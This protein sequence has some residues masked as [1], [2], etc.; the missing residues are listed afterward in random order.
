MSNAIY[1]YLLGDRAACTAPPRRSC[2]SRRRMHSPRDVVLGP[3]RQTTPAR[4]RASASRT[5]D[6][7]ARTG[8]AAAAA[9]GNLSLVV[10][11]LPVMRVAYMVHAGREERR[12]VWVRS[13]GG[14]PPCL[15][16]YWLRGTAHKMR[17]ALSADT[18][19]RPAG[20]REQNSAQVLSA[21]E[22]NVYGTRRPTSSISP[23]DRRTTTRSL[24]I[25]CRRAHSAAHL[26]L[27]L[28]PARRP[29]PARP[30]PPARTL[31]TP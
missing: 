20:I 17:S 10:G 8:D 12:R 2:S 29:L 9:E 24:F 28:P 23:V 30:H 16:H 25:Y 3:Q 18:V 1:Y 7:C 31:L 5:R 14:A 27:A 13:R 21:I 15:I 6:A 19:V 11:R 26:Q 22:V 4:I